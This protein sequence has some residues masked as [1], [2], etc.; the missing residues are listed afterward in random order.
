[1]AKITN[2]LS[3]VWRLLVNMALVLGMVTLLYLI[4]ILVKQ[5]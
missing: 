1:M 3:C 5:L 2:D 4:A